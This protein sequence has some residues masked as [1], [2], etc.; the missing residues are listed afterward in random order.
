MSFQITGSYKCFGTHST[1][2]GVFSCLHSK[3][4][5]N[6]R[7]YLDLE[8]F[9]AFS[10][11]PLKTIY[12]SKIR[13]RDILNIFVHIKNFSMLHSKIGTALKPEPHL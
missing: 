5:F 3:I 1:D 7:I 12:I 9:V 10:Q 6:F 2:V 11:F 13:R 8:Q 4:N